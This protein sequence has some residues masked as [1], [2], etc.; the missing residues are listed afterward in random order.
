MRDMQKVPALIDIF[1]LALFSSGFEDYVKL[2]DIRNILIKEY[3]K[4]KENEQK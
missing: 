2:F 3:I 1:F 4:R